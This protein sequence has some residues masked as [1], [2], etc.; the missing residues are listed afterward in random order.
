MLQPVV[1]WR[2][3]SGIYFTQLS[4]RPAGAVLL[5]IS[6]LD[7]G[8][9]VMAW[10]VMKAQGGSTL[11]PSEAAHAWIEELPFAS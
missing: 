6:V 7:D 8:G 3:P 2:D 10:E 1:W 9:V 4:D 5:E 11:V